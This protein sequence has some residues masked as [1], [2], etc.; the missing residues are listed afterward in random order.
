MG[1]RG[2]EEGEEEGE[3]DGRWD[4]EE[5]EDVEEGAEGYEEMA[6]QEESRAQEMGERGRPRWALS[7]SCCLQP[8]LSNSATL[9]SATELR[10]CVESCLLVQKRW[11]D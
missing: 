2:E 9:R 10:N 3:E 4:A 6:Y 1:E 5:E 8:A 11:E 7:R